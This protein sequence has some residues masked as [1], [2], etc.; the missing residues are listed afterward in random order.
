MTKEQSNK[1][2]KY[3]DINNE[4]S[5]PLKKQKTEQ[6]LTLHNITITGQKKTKIFTSFKDYD[7]PEFIVKSLKRQNFSTPT[8]IQAVSLPIALK[9]KDLI[10]IAET[11]KYI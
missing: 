7:F 8:P 11:G 5:S 1:K 4:T 6:Y 3:S 10:G 9:K 2:R